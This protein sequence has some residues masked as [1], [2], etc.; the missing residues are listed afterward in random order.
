[1]PGLAHAAFGPLVMGAEMA[2][3]EKL[4]DGRSTGLGW[5]LLDGDMQQPT[6]QWCRR[7]GGGRWKGDANGRNARGRTCTHRFGW[8]IERQKNK[9][10][11]GDGALHLDGSCW[12]GKHNN[13]PK[14]SLIIGIFLGET[15]RRTAAVGEDAVESFWPSDFGQKN[16][17]TEIRCGFR[18]PPIVHCT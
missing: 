8:Q 14:V 17:Y 10:R 3:M 2:P 11:E 4:R 1:M 18:Q 13:Q 6:E 16:E 5:L 9:N 12:M 15:A 7:G